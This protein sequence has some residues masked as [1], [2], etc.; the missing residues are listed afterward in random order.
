MQPTFGPT[1]VPNSPPAIGPTSVANTPPTASPT[2][3]P[4]PM[5]NLPIGAIL[6]ILQG[7]GVPPPVDP[8]LTSSVRQN[9]QPRK[10]SRVRR[11]PSPQRFG[12]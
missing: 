4:D 7:G 1:S 10:G 11:Q 5:A 6:Q 8:A 12:R 3:V 9:A 2:S